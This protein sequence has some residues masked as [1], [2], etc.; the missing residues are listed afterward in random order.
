VRQTPGLEPPSRCSGREQLSPA[1]SP[2]HASTE[3]AGGVRPQKTTVLARSV[4]QVPAKVRP[5]G[6]VAEQAPPAA[7]P[8]QAFTRKPGGPGGVGTHARPAPSRVVR[9]LPGREKPPSRLPES[10]HAS[11]VAFPEQAFN[12]P[13]EGAHRRGPVAMLLPPS[14]GVVVL[15]AVAVLAALP[16]A[17]GAVELLHPS[18][19]M[20]AR[21]T[22]ASA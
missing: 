7:L 21:L 14:W 6:P 11:P 20:A 16:P 19:P 18:N 13:S 17:V 2:A 3:A 15:V 8:L 4:L 10:A 9:Q 12:I 5:E 1:A 22:R